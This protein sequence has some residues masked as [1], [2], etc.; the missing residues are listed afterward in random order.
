MSGSTSASFKSREPY[1]DTEVACKV[2]DQHGSVCGETESLGILEQ[3]Q[4]VY[5]DRLKRLDG[6][7]EVGHQTYIVCIQE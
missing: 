2:T 4:R 1:K 5:A 3:F 6:D 7:S